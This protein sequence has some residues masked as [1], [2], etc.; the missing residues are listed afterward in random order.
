MRDRSA[1]LYCSLCVLQQAYPKGQSSSSSRSGS[2]RLL[3]RSSTCVGGR[4][5]WPSSTDS[6]SGDTGRWV[7]ADRVGTTIQE[8]F[9][10]VNNTGLRAVF[11]ASLSSRPGPGPVFSVF[12][13]S[14]QIVLTS[15]RSSFLYMAGLHTGMGP[16]MQFVHSC[17]AVESRRQYTGE[18]K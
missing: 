6:T 13:F 9:C 15:H 7:L 5:E 14:Q 11:F 10:S 18:G 1:S 16:A 8:S 4:R 17:T 12:F 3:T 2:I